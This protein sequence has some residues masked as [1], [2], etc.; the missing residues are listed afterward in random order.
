[1]LRVHPMR[2]ACRTGCGTPLLAWKP[3]GRG[4][5]AC[6]LTIPLV[7]LG[8]IPA[9]VAG[10][11]A[12]NHL[13]DRLQVGGYLTSVMLGSKVRVDGSQGNVGTEIDPEDDLGL[14][15]IKI[16]PRFAVRWRPGRRH[17][18]EGGYQ[19]ARRDAERVLT[20]DFE[21]ADTMFTAGLR[22][23]STFGT[24]QAFLNYR[25]AVLARE[26]TQAGLA[27]GLG[28]LFLTTSLD[29]LAGV[30]GGGQ[31]DSVAFNASKNLVGPTGSVGAFGRF[32]LGTS[33]YLGADLR[34]VKVAIDR[35]DA[36]V[37][38]GGLAV[39]YFVSSRVGVE[40]GYGVSAITVDI[41]PKSS[42]DPGST[43]KIKYSLQHLRLGIV[44]AM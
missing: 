7:A 41:G 16:Q 36:S 17:Q 34:G 33:W 24:D 15:R 42:D 12:P 4:R 9:A 32:V 8:L 20:K 10:Q 5:G 11:A 29:G 31:S 43:G 13:Y 19:F 28:A 35:F 3:L 1:M 44:Y 37:V 39:D 2:A 40:A 38:E 22:V 21:F 27:V 14:S 6:A 30:A 23:R 18:L 25:F 26:K